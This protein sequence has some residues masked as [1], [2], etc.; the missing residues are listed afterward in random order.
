MQDAKAQKRE[1]LQEYTEEYPAQMTEH[2]EVLECFC[3]KE[4]CDTLLAR[5]RSSGKKVVVKCYYNDHP[6]YEE[7]EPIQLRGLAH[8]GIPAYEG[9]YRSGVMRCILRE[10]VEGVSLWECADGTFPTDFVCK[11]GIEM[12]GILEYLHGQEPPVVH[13]DIKPQ[14]VIL[15]K[16]GTVALI[17]FGIS[18]LYKEKET[19]DTLPCGTRDFAP[20]E[21]YGFGQTDRRSDI[22]SMGM[23]LIWML[24]GE[25]KKIQTPA[26][27]LEKILKKCTAFAPKERYDSARTVSVRL[28]RLTAGQRKRR[29]KIAGGVLL[30]SLIFAAAA[31]AFYVWQG[32]R[33]VAFREPLIEEAVRAELEQPYGVI[34]KDD[35]LD[36][37]ELYIHGNTVTTNIDDYYASVDAWFAD[38]MVYGSLASLDDLCAMKNLRTVCIGGERITDISPLSELAYLEK[39]EFWFNDISRID[40]IGGKQY[41]TQVGFGNNPLTDVSALADCPAVRSIVLGN[42]GSFDGKPLAELDGLALLDITSDTDAWKYLSGKSIAVLKLGGPDLTDLSCIKD[43]ARV[44][45]LYIYR[46]K[47]TDISALEGRGNITYLNMAGCQIE[48]LSPLFTMPSLR[49]VVLD[50][51]MKEQMDALLA[52]HGKKAVFEVEYAE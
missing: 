34:T 5:E 20:P 11:V 28:K 7:T 42:A 39:V 45:E 3:H 30:T 24:T 49:T 8:S 21:Q 25:A 17:D 50:A 32:E 43:M 13:R 37:T 31:L 16:D 33:A 35:L 52:E 46:S 36:V 48:D 41:L 18:R 1:F 40:A 27:P 2:Y 38:G 10:Y 15:K 9:E 22:Y 6:F 47:I 12:C 14:N 26:T 4:A 44:E 29:R 23:L 19:R 51:G